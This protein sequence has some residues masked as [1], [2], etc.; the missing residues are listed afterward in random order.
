MS[1]VGDKI[2]PMKDGALSQAAA[3]NQQESAAVQRNLETSVC[4][5]IAVEEG[6][7]FGVPPHQS[8]SNTLASGSNSHPLKSKNTQSRHIQ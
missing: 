6:Q 7:L 3:Q 1:S 8:P 5:G 2:G 4:C